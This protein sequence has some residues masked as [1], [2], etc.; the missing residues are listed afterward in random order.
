MLLGVVMSVHC[1]F[2]LLGLGAAF[3]GFS[4]TLG[5]CLAVFTLFALFHNADAA[6][7]VDFDRLIQDG[8]SPVALKIMEKQAFYGLISSS[9]K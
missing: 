5:I 8:E 1:R 4:L 2:G 3:G 6:S 7:L 9:V